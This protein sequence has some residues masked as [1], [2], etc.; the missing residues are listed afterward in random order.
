LSVRW[1]LL[2][3]VGEAAW[4]LLVDRRNDPFRTL[5]RKVA[6]AGMVILTCLFTWYYVRDIRRARRS[7]KREVTAEENAFYRLSVRRATALL[8]VLVALAVLMAVT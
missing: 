5:K 2:L 4:W 7:P 8:F 3:G 6:G 1:V